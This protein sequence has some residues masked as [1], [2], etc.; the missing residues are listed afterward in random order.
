MNSNEL[1][2]IAPS[3]PMA[4]LLAVTGLTAVLT[5][6]AMLRTRHR[7]GAFV[8]GSAWLRYIMQALHTVTYKPVVA[9]MSANAVGSIGLFLIGLLTINWRHLALRLLTPFYVLIAIAMASAL[10]NGDIGPSLITVLTK[11]GYLIVV[12]LSVFGAM[13]SAQGGDSF[14]VSLLW[15]FAPVAVFQLLSIVLGVSKATER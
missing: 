5:L 10:A 3:L 7:A 11:Y 1:G 13:R 14:L 6:W 8:I 15:A 2:L 12:T 9:G 4:L